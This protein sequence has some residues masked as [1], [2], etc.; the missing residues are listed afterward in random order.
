MIAMNF[1]FYLGIQR[2]LQKRKQTDINIQTANNGNEWQA[3]QS[4]LK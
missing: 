1:S 4:L 2:A 3:I